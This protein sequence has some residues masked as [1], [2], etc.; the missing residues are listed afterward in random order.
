MKKLFFVLIAIVSLTAVDATAQTRVGTSEVDASATSSSTTV[1]VPAT[2]DYAVALWTNYHGSSTDGGLSALTLGGTSFFPV[3]VVVRAA[4]FGDHAGVGAA[5]LSNP[6]TGSPTLAWTWDTAITGGGH[7]FLIYVDDGA[8][9]SEVL[10]AE[11]DGDD[12]QLA[13]SLAP[14]SV[15]G[16]LVF[17]M[18]ASF[19]GTTANIDETATL[20]SSD[21]IEDAGFNV[22][23]R[24]YDVDEG[25]T[26]TPVTQ[27]PSFFGGLVA[28]SI[29]AGAA[30]GSAVPIIL[31]QH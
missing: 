1:T 20:L 25:A 26:T 13:F 29:Q 19:N 22:E 6:S 7:L 24:V 11:A 31:Q 9:P 28:I 18:S 27:D 23:A 14:D 21:P 8:G 30:T 4:A 17:A 15:T 10:D 2:A 5:V 3:E 16:G 12:D